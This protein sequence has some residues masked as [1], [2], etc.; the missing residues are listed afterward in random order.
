[1]EVGITGL[2]DTWTTNWTNDRDQGG[3]GRRK[4]GNK[5]GER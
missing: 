4:G 2:V 3:G 1:M 5:R